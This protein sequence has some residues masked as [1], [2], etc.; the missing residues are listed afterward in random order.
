MMASEEETGGCEM[1]RDLTLA[2]EIQME[3]ESELLIFCA[4]IAPTGC[5]TPLK[6]S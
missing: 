3:Q 1:G 6:Q 2:E 5:Y 4:G